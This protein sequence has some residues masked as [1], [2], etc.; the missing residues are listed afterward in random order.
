MAMHRSLFIGA[1]LSI[2]GGYQNALFEAERMGATAVQIFTTN[3]RQW[4]GHKISEKEVALWK[5]ARKQ[6]HIDVIASHGSYLINLGSPNKAPLAKSRKAFQEEIE[7]CHLL[8]I[9][10]LVFHPGSALESKEEECLQTI[11]DSLLECEEK[12]KEGNT[13]LL[14]ETTAGQGSQVGYSFEQLATILHKVHKKIPVGVCVDTCHIFT[15]G[16]DIR[17]KE[18]WQKTLHTFDQTIGLD[19]LYAFHVNDSLKEC[20]SRLD[21]HAPLGEGCIGLPS[22]EWLMANPKTRLIPK[23]L[24]TP[25][26]EKW[27]KEIQLLRKFGEK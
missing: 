11:V 12:I 6:T 10:F 21:R 14:L 5:E 27:E 26:P 2:A 7:R 9:P 8:E 24:E 17:T 4:H 1:H 20:G 16:Y 3:Q 19:F 22:F 25:I 18:G 15:A 23:Y 13:R